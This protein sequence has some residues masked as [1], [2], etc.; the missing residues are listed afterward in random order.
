MRNG[1]TLTDF[2]IEEQCRH[3]EATGEF[4]GLLTDLLHPAKIISR[5]V[6]KARLAEIMGITGRT[7]I[8]GE[9]VQK[10]DKLANSPVIRTTGQTGRLSGLASEEMLVYTTGS[11]THGF[12]LDLSIGELM[13]LQATELHQPIPLFIGSM[14]DVETLVEFAAG[15]RTQKRVEGVRVSPL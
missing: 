12:I 2:I 10:L 8:H 3:P 14:D 11:G 6:H 15:K 5:D 9:Q 1:T 13:Q 7:N 4:T